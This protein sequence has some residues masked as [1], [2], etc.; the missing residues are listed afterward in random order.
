M[1][2]KHLQRS[3]AFFQSIGAYASYLSSNTLIHSNYSFCDMC[4]D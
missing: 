1:E 2:R 4:L 3:G